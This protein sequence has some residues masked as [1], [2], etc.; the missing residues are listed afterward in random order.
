M[1]YNPEALREDMLR[2]RPYQ[3]SYAE[4]WWSRKAEYRL[5]EEWASWLRDHEDP[6]SG[7][8]YPDRGATI[9][10]VLHMSLPT[11]IDMLMDVI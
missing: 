7:D 4:R 2:D 5:W 10:Y 11:F 8:F 3:E 6:G 9:P 1:D